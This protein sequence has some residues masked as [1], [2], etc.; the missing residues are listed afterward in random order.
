MMTSIVTCRFPAI[1]PVPQ[2][3]AAPA[4]PT[5]VATTNRSGCTLVAGA[6]N[7]L[8]K[9]RAATQRNGP[10]PRIQAGFR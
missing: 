9:P 2:A 8:R 1:A 7:P 4:S 6:A 3:N 10:Q 5:T